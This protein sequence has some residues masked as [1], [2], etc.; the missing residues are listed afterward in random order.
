MEVFEEDD[1]DFGEITQLASLSHQ[2]TT[3]AP[4]VRNVGALLYTSDCP[5][6]P[7]FRQPANHPPAFRATCSKFQCR[8]TDEEASL[9]QQ[10]S[11]QGHFY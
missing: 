7:Q 5:R 9:S 6:R 4:A 8:P 10:L 11:L 2:P 1:D 3:A